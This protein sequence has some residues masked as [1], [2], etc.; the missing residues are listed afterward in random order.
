MNIWSLTWRKLYWSWNTFQ[1][2]NKHLSQK[3]D[4]SSEVFICSLCPEMPRQAVCVSCEAQTQTQFVT[5]GKLEL[6]INLHSMPTK[7]PVHGIAHRQ[8]YFYF[9]VVSWERTEGILL[10]PR[11]VHSVFSV[12]IIGGTSDFWASLSKELGYFWHIELIRW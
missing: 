3:D 2:S 1:F 11:L 7:A 8:H 4:G 12:P 9:F 6:E 10:S 5:P